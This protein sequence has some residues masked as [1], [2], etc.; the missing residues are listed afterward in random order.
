MSDL[1][2]YMDDC[3]IQAKTREARVAEMRERAALEEKLEAET[4]AETERLVRAIEWTNDLAA[5]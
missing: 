2:R 1:I 3:I 5:C 4:R